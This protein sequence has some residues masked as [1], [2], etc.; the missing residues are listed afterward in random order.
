MAEVIMSAIQILSPQLA[1]QIAAGEVVERPSSVVKELV[2]NSL[3]AGASRIDI[4]IERGGAKL[5]RIHDNGSGIAK[6]DLTLALERHATS[7]I[8]T[9]EDLAAIMSMG[10]RG[11]ALASIS[12]VSRLILTS[13]VETQTE[14]WQAYAEGREMNVSLKPAAHP[15]GT[16]VEVLDLFYNTPARRKFLRTEKTEFSHIDEIVRRIA[17]ARFDVAINLHHNGKLVRQYRAT[18]S[19]EQYERRLAAI[20]GT[21]FIQNALKLCWQHGDLAI[22]GWITNPYLGKAAEIQ[23]CYVNGRIMRDRL[24][25]HAIRQA[26]ANRLQEEQQA[27]YVLYLTIDPHQVDVNVHPAKQEVRFHQARLVHDFIYQG[28]NTVLSQQHQ[29][30]FNQVSVSSNQE[31]HLASG[32]QNRLAAGENFFAS[33]DSKQHL[34]IKEQEAQ[35]IT[36]LSASSQISPSKTASFPCYN[37]GKIAKKIYNKKQGELYQQL[38]Q[39]EPAKQEK[40]PLFPERESIKT[41]KI[42]V[43]S[44]DIEKN[45][46]N[47]TFGKILTIYSKNFA[48][49]ESSF[50]IG[51]LSLAEAERYLKR[52]QLIPTDK[53]LKS[54][55]LLIPIKL[56]LTE[57]EIET[58]YRVKVL[59]STLGFDINISHNKATISGVSCPLRSQNLAELFPKLLKYL[60]QNTSCQLMELVVWLADHL[61]NEK[62]VWTI[63]QGVQLLADLERAYPELVKEPPKTLLQLIDF[64]SVI[65]ALTHE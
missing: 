28:V 26:Y 37:N 29:K 63:A 32:L 49:I 8:A 65:T 7:K 19:E 31:T 16:T 52:S 56:A 54:Q 61:V 50:G 25:N 14:A 27:A 38:M 35:V 23:Y 18:N 55:P 39:N 57:K 43:K 10:F 41:E 30:Q 5:I 13:R 3:D 47:Y 4:E 34:V 51:L 46:K 53:E 2:E 44:V 45:D 24:I 58:F 22:K 9:L 20:C 17:L 42:A 36:E 1:N 59:L 40:I 33:D 48:F 62:Q 60:A 6:E 11:E 21:S 64:E 12:S 15:I